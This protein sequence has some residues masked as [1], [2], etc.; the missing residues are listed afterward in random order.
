[1]AG[2]GKAGRDELS[3]Q[4]PTTTGGEEYVCAV[5]E[6]WVVGLVPSLKPSSYYRIFSFLEFENPEVSLSWFYV[7]NCMA[8]FFF[9]WESVP[10]NGLG[11]EPLAIRLVG[12]ST[13]KYSMV[14]AKTAAYP[15]TWNSYGCIYL[16]IYKK[17]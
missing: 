14:Y 2:L 8:H 12:K 11:R 7:G 17:R 10:E 13:L 5:V 15:S 16:K 3:G 1:M 4:L 6:R 9:V